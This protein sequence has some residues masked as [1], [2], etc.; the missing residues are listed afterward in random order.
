MQIKKIAAYVLW[1]SWRLNDN[2]QSAW[3]PFVRLLNAVYVGVGLLPRDFRAAE[4]GQIIG[5]AWQNVDRKKPIQVVVFCATLAMFFCAAGGLL[6]G[7]LREAMGT[8]FAQEAL[9]TLAQSDYAQTWLQQVFGVTSGSST[10]GIQSGLGNMLMV[11]NAVAGSLGGF[12]AL[13]S[14]SIFV[15]ESGQHGR[16]GG[17]RHSVFWGPVRLVTAA[18][19]LVPLPSGWNSGEMAVILAMQQASAGASKVLAA[20]VQGKGAIVTPYIPST[21]GVIG[22]ILVNE[23]CRLSFNAMASKAGDSS[24]V[25]VNTERMLKAPGLLASKDD[26]VVQT[27]EGGHV[28]AVEWSYDGTGSYPRKTCGSVRFVPPD[29][30]SGQGAQMMISTHRDALMSVMPDIVS[31][32]DA[33]RKAN[34]PD[35][36]QRAA[37]PSTSTLQ[38]IVSKYNAAI[39]DKISAAV[40]AQNGSLQQELGQDIKSAGWVAAPVWFTT[41][42]RLN[43]Q[44]LESAYSTPQIGGPTAEYSWPSEVLE[45]VTSADRYWHATVPRLL[46]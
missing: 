36:R 3:Q 16:P 25:T 32:A 15:L 38:S 13:Y 24:Y 22:Q 45:A 6:F 14:I 29:S 43:G 5:Q 31:L 33:I 46:V 17:Q 21:Q 41:L 26:Y 42:S 44:I 10:G 11:Y 9:A 37:L 2:I 34:D 20:Y 40:E 4:L 7:L 19:F 12:L 39:A 1:P 8:A 30:M 27:T 18:A 28:S 23:T 35:V